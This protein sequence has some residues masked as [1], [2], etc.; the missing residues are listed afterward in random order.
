[1]GSENVKGHN[2]TCCTS[3]PVASQSAEMLLM[4]E[5]RCARKALAVSLD[6]SALQRFAVRMRS[7]GTHCWYTLL[8]TSMARFPLVVGLPP[9]ST[10]RSKEVLVPAT[11][12]AGAVVVAATD[13]ALR[14]K[15]RSGFGAQGRSCQS[16]L[17]TG[18]G[19]G[20]PPVCKGLALGVACGVPNQ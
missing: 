5:M 18:F 6:S 12:L 13:A 2:R 10:C 1:M 9:I 7:A 3:A 16:S 20:G 11:S 8:S 15:A 17:G 4:E 19:A 14:K